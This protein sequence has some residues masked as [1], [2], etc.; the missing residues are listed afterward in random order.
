MKLLTIIMMGYLFFN[1]AFAQVEDDY[2]FTNP[3]QQKQFTRLIHELRCLV[4]QN[5]SLA[6]SNAP[7]A[8]DLRNEVYQQ[9][10]QQ[11]RDEAIIN[12]LTQRYVDFVLLRPP[13]NK[14]T[15]FLW[16][17]P[18]ILMLI[19]IAIL[20]LMTSRAKKS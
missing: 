7:L 6:E 11:Q 16:F 5:Q 12:F 18:I 15:W 2:Q 1:M 17:A 3:Q 20:I 4:C 10:I 14:I 19:G 8:A 13:V 9:V